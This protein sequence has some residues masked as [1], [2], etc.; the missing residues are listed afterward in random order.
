MAARAVAQDRLPRL[1]VQTVPAYSASTDALLIVRAPTYCGYTPAAAPSVT[2]SAQILEISFNDTLS[3]F[4]CETGNPGSPQFQRT[5]IRDLQ[6]LLGPRFLPSRLQ[7]QLTVTLDGRQ[8]SRRNITFDAIPPRMREVPLPTSSAW[9]FDLAAYRSGRQLVWTLPED[10]FRSDF[11]R[12]PLKPGVMRGR[13]LGRGFS[14]LITDFIVVLKSPS[15][16]IVGSEGAFMELKIAGQAGEPLE[17]ALVGQWQVL[18]RGDTV[19]RGEIISIEA[20]P[21]PVMGFFQER[22]AFRFSAGSGRVDCSRE[23]GCRV[24]AQVDGVDVSLQVATLPLDGIT[25]DRLYTRR[26]DPVEGELWE[27]FAVRVE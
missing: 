1:E 13:G 11:G 8:V 20:T 19:L 17:P 16:A 14:T 3:E 23:S 4:G 22:F 21:R 5:A 24:S 9:T 7:V 18:D 12:V 10:G 27:L 25:G 15:E 2:L 26:V 6:E